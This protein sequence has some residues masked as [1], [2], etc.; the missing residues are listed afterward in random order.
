MSS[1]DLHLA[2][3]HNMGDLGYVRAWGGGGM[4]GELRPGDF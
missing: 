3:Y 1:Q 4:R 2:D